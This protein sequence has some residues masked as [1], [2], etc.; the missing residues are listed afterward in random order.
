MLPGAGLMHSDGSIAVQLRLRPPPTMLG[1]TQAFRDGR[2]FSFCHRD[3]NAA[4]GPL[5]DQAGHQYQ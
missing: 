2:L 5:A 3:S 4:D 1:F